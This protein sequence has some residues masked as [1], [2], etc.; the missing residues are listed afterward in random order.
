MIALR[1]IVDPI[2]LLALSRPEAAPSVEEDSGGWDSGA[3][4]MGVSDC[5]VVN[6]SFVC[7]DG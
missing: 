6:C 5:L 7:A 4:D 2:S 3:C 1:L